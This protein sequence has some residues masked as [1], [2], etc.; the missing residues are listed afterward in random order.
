MKWDLNF[1]QTN[2][3]VQKQRVRYRRMKSRLKELTAGISLRVKEK[4]HKLLEKKE[5]LDSRFEAKKAGRSLLVLTLTNFRF[6]IGSGQD[7]FDALSI[8]ARTTSKYFEAIFDYNMAIA[9]LNGPRG[10]T[11]TR[12][13]ARLPQDLAAGRYF[14]RVYTSTHRGNPAEYVLTLMPTPESD[15]PPVVW[16]L[17]LPLLLLLLCGL[18]IVLLGRPLR[19][20]LPFVAVL[21]GGALCWAL[22]L[23]L[24]LL[25]S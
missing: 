17:T 25:I 15:L 5:S 10:V 4:Y 16:A 2:A 23:T 3:E 24:P 8:F 20:R 18:L 19:S 11:P 21:L 6:G 22:A 1:F 13:T 14:V 12:V 7:L 9:E